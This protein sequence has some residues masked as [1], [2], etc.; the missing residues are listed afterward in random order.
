[1]PSPH[2]N[3]ILGKV[4]RELERQDKKWGEQNHRDGVWFSEVE[5]EPR[6]AKDLKLTEHEARAW[7]DA[8]FKAGKGTWRDILFEETCEAFAAASP[9]ELENELV[10][11]AAVAVAWIEAIQRRE[12]D[13]S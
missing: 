5:D 3:F 10:Q 1:M 4:F 7:A 9:E 8:R 11:V 6:F 2:R 13:G 12:H